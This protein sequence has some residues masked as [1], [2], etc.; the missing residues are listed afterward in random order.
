MKIVVSSAKI[1]KKVH[2]VKVEVLLSLK[3]IL[4]RAH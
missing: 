4:T 1:E 3:E 2:E